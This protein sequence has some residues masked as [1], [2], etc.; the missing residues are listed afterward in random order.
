MKRLSIEIQVHDMRKSKWGVSNLEP[1]QDAVLTM[2][3][4]MDI[5]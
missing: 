4:Q 5:P 1:N 2:L 3:S